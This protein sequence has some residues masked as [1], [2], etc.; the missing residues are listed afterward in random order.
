MSD[1]VL[2]QDDFL[3][4]LEKEFG[5]SHPEDSNDE[6]DDLDLDL[7]GFCLMA[8]FLY[9]ER[10]SY[11]VHERMDWSQHV[12]HL[13]HTDRFH[14]KY[15]MS[16]ESFDKLVD[17]LRPDIEVDIVKARNRCNQE[18]YPEIVVAICIRY[19]CGGSYDDI[20]NCYGVSIGGY[21][22]SRNKF[23]NS[24]LRCEALAITMPAT[25]NEWEDIRKRFE[26]KSTEG[27]MRGTI[28]AIDGFF[29]PTKCPT[30]KECERNP[31]VYFSGHYV[32]YGVNCQAICDS[33]LRFMYF[34]VIA[35]GTVGDQVA[36][37]DTGL[38]D[39]IESF[40]PGLFIVADAAYTLTEH[41][42]V[43]FTGS[44]RLHKEKDTFNYFLSQLRIQIEMAF[45]L[46]TTKWRILR[47]K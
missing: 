23:L 26:A 28:G 11:W 18:I 4:D 29:Q 38:S 14:C 17:H 13:Q 3:S 47:R 36:Y 27:I 41:M 21:Y 43:P 25:E 24:I 39:V 45:G 44:N 35:P 19:L 42:L 30:L 1:Y 31:R 2:F 34:G 5:L 20:S 8:S 32:S 10:Q 9:G 6:W 37:E 33:R 12:K 7:E 15:R 46:L 40:P 22:Y 16:K